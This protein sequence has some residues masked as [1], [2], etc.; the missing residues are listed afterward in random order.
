MAAHLQPEPRPPRLRS[1]ALAPVCLK[2]VLAMLAHDPPGKPPTRVCRCHP[3]V[4]LRSSQPPLQHSQLSLFVS[5]P[6]PLSLVSVL[7]RP[8]PQVGSVNNTFGIKGVEQYCYYFKSIEDANRL[9]GR[10]SECF[11]RAA[12]PATPE[13]VGTATAL[14]TTALRSPYTGVCKL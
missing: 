3:P 14:R 4:S 5:Y 10:V 13:E 6:C 8:L 2:G 7:P 1:A 9:R 12:L 11:E